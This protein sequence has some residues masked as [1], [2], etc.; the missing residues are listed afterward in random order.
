M[1][2][3][4]R[5]FAR[6]A[7]RVL[8]QA[9]AALAVLAVVVVAATAGWLWRARGAA[10][11][12]RYPEITAVIMARVDRDANGSVSAAEYGAVSMPTEPLVRYDL[13]LDGAL[14]PAEIE[15]IFLDAKITRPLLPPMPR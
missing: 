5:R 4:R 14:T 7:R 2:L 13:D 11:A 6:R 3:A 10:S 12:L 8:P 15:A 9:L 1:R